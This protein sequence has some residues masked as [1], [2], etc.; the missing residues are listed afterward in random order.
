M[1]SIPFLVQNAISGMED[2]GAAGARYSV[3]DSPHAW[4]QRAMAHRQGKL[5]AELCGRMDVV[6]RFQRSAG[7]LTVRN[8]SALGVCPRPMRNASEQS[9]PPK[10]TAALEILS[11]GGLTHRRR[12]DRKI[13]MAAREFD[14][15]SPMAGSPQRKTD[16]RNNFIW[17]D[18]RCHERHWKGEKGN[19]PP[20]VRALHH[21]RRIV[22]ARDQNY[23]CC[24]I[25]MTKRAADRAAVAGKIGD[26]DIALVSHR[27]NFYGAGGFHGCRKAHQPH[28]D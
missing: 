18:G 15:G 24:R 5:L 7:L 14:K 26:F 6:G 10:A 23:F 9:N 4:G 16:G 1:L 19:L 13:P 20:T 21:H 12:H 8:S 3:A 17:F 2:T 25:E 28:L 11:C 27:A 22:H